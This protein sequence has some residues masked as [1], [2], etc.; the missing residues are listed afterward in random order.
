MT[1]PF[2]KVCGITR[3]EDAIAAVAAGAHAIGFVFVPESPRAITPEAARAIGSELPRQVAR[4]GVVRDLGAAELE[5]L[6]RSANLT[7]L[8]LHGNEPPELCA[9]LSVRTV[10]AFA[11]G[12]GFDLAR[13]TPFRDVPVLLD[14]GTESGQGGTGQSADWGIARAARTQGFRVLLAGGLGPQNVVRAF[15]DVRPI[16]VDLNSAVERAPGVKDSRL[17]VD[18]FR[19]L[20]AFDPPEVTTWPW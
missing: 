12:P 15:E 3:R 6:V 7:A 14:G 4:V 2:V 5:E 11:A 20:L 9:R 13:L 17:I 19:V 1:G 16:A 18:A 10:K 8:Q